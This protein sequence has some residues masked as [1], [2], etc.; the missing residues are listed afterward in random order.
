MDDDGAVALAQELFTNT[1]L[2]EL[3]LNDNEIGDVGV[4]AL[5][6]AL[7]VNQSLQMLFLSDNCISCIGACQLAQ[8]ITVNTSLQGLYLNNNSIGDSGAAALAQA[9]Q[10]NTSLQELNLQDND[11]ISEQGGKLLL[12]TLEKHNGTL[13]ELSLFG[14]A[15]EPTTHSL[16]RF[17][18]VA[19][20]ANQTKTRNPLPRPRTTSELFFQVLQDIKTDDTTQEDARSS[21]VPQLE[22]VLQFTSNLLQLSIFYTTVSAHY[23]LGVLDVKD[24][25][26]LLS[27]AVQVAQKWCTSADASAF[28][29]M[30]LDKAQADGIISV[31]QKY[32]WEAHATVTLVE[33]ASFTQTMK[34]ALPRK[35][36]SGETNTK[37]H[38]TT[39]TAA[40]LVEHHVDFV[41]AMQQGLLRNYHTTADNDSTEN[42]WSNRLESL[43]DQ[44]QIVNDQELQ[45][46]M[47]HKQRIEA[48]VTF[49]S[50]IVHVLRGAAANVTAVENGMTAGLFQVIDFSD[51]RHIQSIL[52]MEAAS[53]TC[54]SDLIRQGQTLATERAD[55]RLDDAIVVAPNPIALIAAFATL[56]GSSTMRGRSST[57]MPDHQGVL[58]GN[59]RTVVDASAILDTVSAAQDRSSET[60]AVFPKNDHCFDAH[61]LDQG[62]TKQVFQASLERKDLENKQLPVF[63]AIF[64]GHISDLEKELSRERVDLARRDS[65]NRTCADFAAVMGRLD[66]VQLID[67]KGGPFVVNSRPNMMAL[68]RERYDIVRN[69]QLD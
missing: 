26:R 9:L 5:S 44:L 2:Q 45:G 34:Q 16:Q 36:K 8:A 38:N 69:G 10:V 58:Y 14:N 19:V 17:I 25:D 46:A 57:T 24:R 22:T 42:N 52:T 41:K 37:T 60:T 62:G 13:V 28:Y 65:R 21:I 54:V 3:H 23:K 51:V 20:T 64:H 67:D 47:L 61:E 63:A 40:T 27:N 49:V 33:H 31:L 43:Q 59:D 4:T 29:R 68:A 12:E 15:D 39:T 6:Q 55:E 32:K 48:G 1:S 66:M 30:A 35:Q 7:Q 50:A 11:D 18:N 56:L 53:E